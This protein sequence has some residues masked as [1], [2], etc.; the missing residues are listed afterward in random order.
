MTERLS[1]RVR[2]AIQA[3][4]DAKYAEDKLFDYVH[5][6]SSEERMQVRSKLAYSGVE[7]L[8]ELWERAIDCSETEP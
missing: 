7:R 3:V 2:Q 8:P 4:V 6:L 5:D 1:A